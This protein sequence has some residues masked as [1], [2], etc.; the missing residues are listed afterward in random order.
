M[1]L[2]KDENKENIERK[3]I[4][5]PGEI[6]GTEEEYL[7]GRGT[8]SHNGVIRTAVMGELHVDQK[9]RATIVPFERL[10]DIK[11]GNVV[12][13]KIEEIFES[14]AFVSVEVVQKNKK[15]RTIILPGV[16]PVSEIKTEYVRS[17]RDELRIGDIIVGTISKITPFR[18]EVSL[19]ARG[20]GV[21][22][23]FCTVCRN[24]LQRRGRDLVCPNCGH[25]ETRKLSSQYK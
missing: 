7:A 12:Y 22:K 8:Y 4:K 9:R 13:G 19:K 2:N 5:V 25:R 23:A 16:I 20:M 14:V 3:K 1:D 17:I 18:I 15:E 24:E 10:P 21:V 6:I 11:I